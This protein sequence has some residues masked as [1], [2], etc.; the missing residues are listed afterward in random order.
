MYQRI[1]VPIDDS[2]TSVHALQEACRLAK[3]VG[4]TLVA[5]HVVDLTDLKREANMLPR[6]EELYAIEAQVADH[7]ESIMKEA[8][9][10]YEIETLENDGMRIADVLIKEAARQEC[11][12]IAMGTH[13]FSGLLHLL[14]G[15]VAEGVLRQSHVPVL[16]FRRAD[17]EE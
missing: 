16:L 9:V 7:A 10:P 3:A 14:M 8:G 4:A 6:S 12:L 15:S 5:V 13:G 17:D 2:K 11:D 1:L